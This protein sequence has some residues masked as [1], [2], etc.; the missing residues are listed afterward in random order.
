VLLQAMVN[1]IARESLLS[2]RG[3]VG[4]TGGLLLALSVGFSAG[5]RWNRIALSLVCAALLIALGFGV[6]RG[7]R[8][9]VAFFG[10]LAAAAVRAIWARSFVPR[11]SP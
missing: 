2:P 6:S 3:L 10:L 9:D 7:H 11:R 8:V 5:A 4:A 1:P